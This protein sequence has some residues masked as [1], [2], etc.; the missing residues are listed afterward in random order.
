MMWFGSMTMLM[1][2]AVA[3]VEKDV[4]KIV[5]LS[6]LS[7]LG[8]MMVALALEKKDLCFF[9]LITHAL[10]KALL[11]ICVGV[12]IHTVFGTQDLRS[13]GE[14]GRGAAFPLRLMWVSS[15]ALVGLPFLA[16][17]YRKDMIVESFYTSYSRYWAGCFFFVGIG[18][19]AAYR[20]KIFEKV[21]VGGEGVLPITIR[22]GGLR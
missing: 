10:F 13:F 3:C 12:L 21:S 22:Y 15:S 19:T 9:H 14:L 20:L 16:G 2:G 4:K 6:T 17:F 18:L 11:F 7:Q 1:A 5:A 8:V